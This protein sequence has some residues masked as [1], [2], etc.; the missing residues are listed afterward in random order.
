MCTR[1]RPIIIIVAV[2]SRQIRLS[3]SNPAFSSLKAINERRTTKTPPNTI[4]HSPESFTA[5][6]GTPLKLTIPVT[7]FVI[8]VTTHKNIGFSQ[9]RL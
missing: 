5:S 6:I 1:E 4:T 8:A 3:T 7:K 9:T 2:V